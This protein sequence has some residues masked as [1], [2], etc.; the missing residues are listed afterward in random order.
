VRRF[1]AAT[2]SGRGASNTPAIAGQTTGVTRLLSHHNLKPL[3]Y[4]VIIHLN[5]LA[6]LSL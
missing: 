2:A 5:I 3:N 6:R 1:C 4:I